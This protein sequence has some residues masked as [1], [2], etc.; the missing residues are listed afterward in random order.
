M[1]GGEKMTTREPTH[2]LMNAI[3]TLKRLLATPRCAEEQFQSW[4]EE[5]PIVFQTL[6]YR[7]WLPQPRLPTDG[8]GRFEPD[9][10]VEDHTG[11]W[12]VFEIKRHDT[13]VLKN[14]HRRTDFRADFSTYIQQCR[15]YAEYF[16][17]SKGRT[18]AFEAYGIHVQK[19]VPSLIVAAVDDV[20]DFS[21]ARSLLVDRSGTVQLTTYSEVLRS[22]ERQLNF[23][24]ADTLGHRGLTVVLLGDLPLDRPEQVLIDFGSDRS[25]SR[26]SLGLS[27]KRVFCSMRDE[28]GETRRW[29]IDR[30]LVL[31]LA[32]GPSLSLLEMQV[33]ISASALHVSV[34]FNR[35]CIMRLKTS[36]IPMDVEKLVGGF[37]VGTNVTGLVPSHFEAVELIIYARTMSPT[38]QLQIYAHLDEVYR[39]YL[40]PLAIR[41]PHAIGFR[42]NH[43]L[44]TPGHPLSKA[45]T[46]PLSDPPSRWGWYSSRHVTL[47][48]GSPGQVD[49]LLGTT[50]IPLPD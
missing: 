25:R 21:V 47:A 46:V 44:F 45:P 9:F 3:S 41:R 35:R 14:P 23:L 49:D 15:E 42:G 11:V 22:L 50:T 24:A 16:R 6:G 19:D 4:F 43:W 17:E 40:S 13:P 33:G 10:L 29:D 34:H 2:D 20:V 48:D 36:A 28:N 30:P 38:E 1:C 5:N 7:K 37:A 27:G 8:G 31:E 12:S 32:N 18:H 39:Y 26:C